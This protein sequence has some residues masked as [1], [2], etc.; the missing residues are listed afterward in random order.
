MKKKSLTYG[1]MFM[2]MT[3]FGI[4]SSTVSTLAYGSFAF[5]EVFY[6]ACLTFGVVL[7]FTSTKIKGHMFAGI[8][9]VNLGFFVNSF[10]WTVEMKSGFAQ[11]LNIIQTALIFVAAL[12]F[13]H[14]Q[15][16]QKKAKT[17]SMSCSLL[18][19]IVI[20][21]VAVYGFITGPANASG[22]LMKGC[23]VVQNLSLLSTLILP[24]I[25]VL[26]N[27]SN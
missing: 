9:L 25:H 13:I 11:I 17:L 10:L 2:I 24:I 20:S 27:K 12:T 22:D 5:F 21:A 18:L 16:G 4:A 23:I 7:I 26:Q 6:F 8:L 1:I 15:F 19:A 14:A 3:A